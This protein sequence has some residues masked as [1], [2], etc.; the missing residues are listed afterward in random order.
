MKITLKRV[1]LCGICLVGSI[2]FFVALAIP[3]KVQYMEGLKSGEYLKE[4][5][6]SFLQCI[7]KKPFHEVFVYNN[8]VEAALVP[9]SAASNPEKFAKIIENSD[10]AMKVF[11]IIAL[12]AIILDICATVGAFFLKD[13]KSARKLLIPFKAVAIVCMFLTISIPG[14]QLSSSIYVGGSTHHLSSPKEGGVFFL[15]F[16]GVL[17]FVGALIAAGVVKD[18]VLVGSKKK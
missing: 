11:A 5:S 16:I 14:S 12:I 7:G 10:N 8:T 4:V 9:T 6:G 17:S 1:L 13:Q 15:F 18:K 2:L 3:F